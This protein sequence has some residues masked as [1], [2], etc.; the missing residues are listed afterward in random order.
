MGTVIECEGRTKMSAKENF[1][2]AMFSMFGVGRDPSAITPT[3]LHN[4]M[5]ADFMPTPEPVSEKPVTPAPVYAPPKVVSM[6]Y[7]APG[8]VMEGKLSAKGDVEIAGDFKGEI[9]ATGHVTLRTSTTGNVTAA[10]LD[11][12]GCV[13]TGDVHTSGLT[14]V[15]ATSSIQG[16]IFAEELFC[17][18]TIKGD[19]VANGNVTLQAGSRVEGN[20]TTGTIVI[21]RDAYFTGALQMNGGK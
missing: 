18:G 16:N 20:I 5:E 14:T 9:S 2:E 10:Q 7:L 6:T 15:D 1:N 13:L 21:E 17:C 12:L 8:T 4:T 19:I 11:V 3:Q